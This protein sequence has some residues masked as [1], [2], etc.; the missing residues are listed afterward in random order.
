[1]RLMMKT[2]C[3]YLLAASIAFGPNECACVRVSRPFF[4]RRMGN[5]IDGEVLGDDFKG[6]I[7]KITGGND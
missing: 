6:Y 2:R 1:M 5:E 7:F 3:K 4:E